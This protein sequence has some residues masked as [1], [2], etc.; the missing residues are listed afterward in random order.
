MQKVTS[1]IL[2]IAITFFCTGLHA[3]VNENDSIKKYK[4]GIFAPVYLDSVFKGNNY[5]YQDN[6]PRFTFQG[7]DFIH[8]AMI[9][10]D[11][12]AFPNARIETYIYDTRSAQGDIDSLIT[13]DKMNDLQL[14]IGSV[15]DNDFSLL[16]DFAREKHIP[17]ISATYPNDGGVTANPFLAIA[18]STLKAHCEAIYA[19]LL[20]NHGTN[21]IILCRKPGL[22]EDRVA[23][24]FRQLNEPDGNAI[25][26]I[27][28][29]N[30]TDS[31]FN[32]IKLKLDSTK[33][34]IIIVGSLDEYFAYKLSAEIAGLHK[35]YP[36]TL[37]GMPNWDV[38]KSFRNKKSF[39]GFPVYIT[40]PYY[41]N[42]L[43]TLSRLL[44]NAYLK[45]YKGVPSD[46][47]YKGFEMTYIFTR[48]LT[49]NP[50]DYMNHLNTNG[51]KV[52]N[53]YNFKPVF[54]SS[55]STPDYFEN[56]HLYFLKLEN[57]KISMAW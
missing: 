43:D 48:L 50:N 27:K 17:F 12:L 36:T 26:N 7:L 38:F 9:A 1:G 41:N 54:N 55:K 20:Q 21:E 30:I 57:G 22:Q 49:T 11:S 47:A 44:Q 23:G 24:Y 29:V 53:T 6:F 31:N 5:K 2:F 32:A 10:L 28:T 51:D 16:A 3:Q 19:Y 4:V 39:T 45:K 8:G 42:K 13:N 18:N 52:F 15:R 46:F 37:Y 56:K 25:M 33:K 34:N 14:I 35:T 40:S